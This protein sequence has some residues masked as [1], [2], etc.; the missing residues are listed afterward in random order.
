MQNQD[1]TTFSYSAPELRSVCI[2]KVD[3]WSYCL[4]LY[5]NFVNG[6]GN[7]PEVLLTPPGRILFLVEWG[8]LGKGRSRVSD[9]ACLS[10]GRKIHDLVLPSLFP[11]PVF[12]PGSL[13]QA[14]PLTYLACLNVF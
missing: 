14:G 1:N 12:A 4:L 6:P 11:A 13:H 8:G 10:L 3:Y 9:P 5:R 7:G 2:S